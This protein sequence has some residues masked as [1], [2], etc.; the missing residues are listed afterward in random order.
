MSPSP[1]APVTPRGSARAEEGPSASTRS[2]PA[3]RA[4]APVLREDDP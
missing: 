3:R 1:P 4:D 2:A